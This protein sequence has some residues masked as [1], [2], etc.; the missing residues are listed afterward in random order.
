MSGWML[1]QLLVVQP[2]MSPAVGSR[3][4]DHSLRCSSSSEPSGA[5][6]VTRRNQTARRDGGSRQPA[7][8]L[9]RQ[10][11]DS[12]PV[13]VHAGGG[14]GGLVERR[15][16]QYFVSIRCD[17]ARRRPNVI[18]CMWGGGGARS[19]R[20]ALPLQLGNPPH[21]RRSGLSSS[22]AHVVCITRAERCSRSNERR[23]SPP[24]SSPDGH[25]LRVSERLFSPTSI[26]N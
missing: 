16:G 24:S 13:Y 26:P 10:L 21:A 6:A 15:G 3:Y 2:A 7:G 1:S 19:M 11:G 14:G 18:V 17:A 4:G 8:R 25:V 5:A 20:A 9:A 22:W 23:S 12:S